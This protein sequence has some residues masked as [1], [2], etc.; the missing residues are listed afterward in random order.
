M[1]TRH[2][3]TLPIALLIGLSLFG[4]IYALTSKAGGTYW[5]QPLSHMADPH[6]PVHSD[7]LTTGE[8]GSFTYTSDLESGQIGPCSTTGTDDPF[9][10][11]FHIF[12]DQAPQATD[13]AWL[14]YELTGLLDHT[15]ICRSINDRPA[16]GGYM[17]CPSNQWITQ[18]EQIPVYG[19]HQGDNV[20]RFTQP[21]EAKTCYSIRALQLEVKT[22]LSKVISP[23]KDIVITIPEYRFYENK[24]YLKG[25]LTGNGAS[26]A[27]VYAGSTPISTLFG[28]FEC[29]LTGIVSDSNTW[30]IPLRAVFPN[31]AEILKTIKLVQKVLPTEVC[32]LPARNA[33]ST[34]L[35]NYSREEYV[36]LKG[37][38]LRLPKGALPENKL[39]MAI[40]LRSADLVPLHTDMVNVTQVAAGYRLLPHGT[41]FSKPVELSLAYDPALI[42]VGYTADDIRTFYFDEAMRQWVPLPRAALQ[43]D[44]A[45]VISYTTHFTDF[46]NGIIKVPES[47]ETQAFQPTSIKALKAANPGAGISMID[48]PSPNY[49]GTANLS[50]PLT[51]PPGRQGV[52]PQLAIQ[53]NSGGGNSWLGLGWDLSLPFIGIETRWGAPRFDSQLETETYLFNSEQLWPTAHRD[54]WAQRYPDGKEFTPRVEGAFDRIVRH[55]NSPKEYWWEVT[56]KNG[57]VN[58]YGGLPGQNVVDSAVLKTP[59]GNIAFWGLVKTVDAN[60]NF[61]RYHYT[62]VM[63]VGLP[64][65]TVSGYQLYPDKITYT[66]HGANEGLYEVRFRRDRQLP[67]N[68]RRPDVE[69]NCR[70]GLK[71]VTA[72]L[73]RKVEIR[74]D[75]NLVRS[76]ELNYKEGPFFKTLLAAIAEFD[77]KGIKFYEHTFDYFDDVNPGGQFTPLTIEEDWIVPDDKV[78]VDL[79]NPLKLFNG[80]T[81]VISGNKSSNFNVGVAVTVGGP[82]NLFSKSNTLG[83]NFSRGQ[84][85]GEG[86]IALVDINGDQLPDKVFKDKNSHQLFYSPNLAS[87][88]GN[89]LAAFGPKQPITGIKE[90]SQIKTKTWAKGLEGHPTPLFVGLTSTDSESATETYFADFNSDGLIDIAFKGIV[91]FNYLD[92]AGNPHFT[93]DSGKTPSYVVANAAVD[94]KLLPYDIDYREQ[95]I[96]D[97]PLHDVIRMWRAPR[98][99]TVSISAPIQLLIDPSPESQEYTKKDGIRYTIQVGKKNELVRD[100]ITNTTQPITKPFQRDGINVSKGEQIYF[101][102]Q[103]R[104]DGAFDQV[105]W[106][107]KIVYENNGNPLSALDADAK[108]IYQYQASSDFLLASAQRITM[109][110]SGQLRYEAPFIKP[111]LSDSITLV[112]LRTNDMG[113]DTLWQQGYGDQETVNTTFLDTLSIL[114]NDELRFLIYTS[115]TIDWQAIRW[116][117]EVAYIDADTDIE[118]FDPNGKPLIKAKPSIE[119]SLFSVER[120]PTKSLTA[121][122]TGKVQVSAGFIPPQDPPGPFYPI[123]QTGFFTIAV[124]KQHELVH[125]ETYEV[126]LLFGASFTLIHSTKPKVVNAGDEIFV[127][128]YFSNDTLAEQLLPYVRSAISYEFSGSDLIDPGAFA[129]LPQQDVLFGNLYRGWGQFA[130][131][132]NRNRAFQK[133]NE[134]ELKIDHTKYKTNIGDV[135][136]S[137][138]LDSNNDPTKE[139]FVLMVVDPELGMWRGYDDLTYVKSD[140]V[141]SSRMGEDDIQFE[142]F[143]A[144]GTGAA[145]PIKVST[146]S[147][148]SF[149]I[150]GSIPIPSPVSIS[151]PSPSISTSTQTNKIELVDMGG[152]GFPDML[153][154]DFVQ[155]TNPQGGLM[156]DLTPHN[157]GVHV[158]KADEFGFSLGGNT[159]VA[160]HSNSNIF[161]ANLI[162]NGES[163]ENANHVPAKAELSLGITGSFGQGNDAV[164]ESWIDINADGLPDKIKLGNNV[165]SVSLNLGYAFTDPE[166]W[167][168]RHI[169]AG[170]TESF[171][172][173]LGVNYSNMSLAFGVGLNRSENYSTD[174]LQ[175][176]NGDGLADMLHVDTSAQGDYRIY[177]YLNKGTEFSDSILWTSSTKRLDEGSATGESINGAFTFCIPLFFIRI[178]VNPQISGGQGVN[179]QFTQITD[180]QG[181]GFPDFIYS[182]DGNQLSVKSSTI[183]RTNLLRTVHRPMGSTFTLDYS[184][185]GNTYAL[186]HSK[187]VL[188]EIDVFDGFKDDGADH[189]YT[190]VLYEGGLHNRRERAF[191]G[192]H[193]VRI[194]QKASE[195]INSV[196]RT[197]VLTFDTS[198]YHRKG[199]LLSQRLIAGAVGN[200]FT[201]TRNTYVLKDVVNGNTL[202]DNFDAIEAKG[203]AFPALVETTELY[204][205][206]SPNA[207]LQHTMTYVYDNWGNVTDYEDQGDGSPGDGAF[208]KI[209]YHDLTGPYIKSVPAGITVS[210]DAGTIRRRETQIDPKG[211]VTRILQYLEDGSSVNHDMVYDDYGNL[212]RITRPPN[213]QDVRLQFEYTYDSAVFTYVTKV[214][215]GY[216][217]SS[218]G[219]FDYAFGQLLEATD[220]NGQ[221]TNYAIDD[222]GRIFRVTGP[223]ELASGQSPYTILY[224]YHPE[225]AEPYAVTRHYDPETKDD[226]VTVTFTDGLQ[227]PIQVK[228]T[229]VITTSPSS[230][231]TPGMIV[232]GRVIFDAFGR[233]VAEYYP[234]VEAPGLETIF[235][236]NFNTVEPTEKQYDVLDR[237]KIITLPDG[238]TTSFEFTIEEDFSGRNCFKTLTTDAEGSKRETY[239]DIRKR[240]YS[241]TDFGPNNAPI[242]TSYRYNPISELLSITDHLG[243]VITY[244]YDHLGRKTSTTHPDAGRTDLTY[245]PAGNVIRK[246]TANL[247][248]TIPNGGAVLYTYDHERLVQV[249]YPKNYQ[250]Q[251][252]IHYGTPGDK[253]NRAGRIWLR[254][255]ATGGTEYFYGPL[256]ETVKEI[257]TVLVDEFT[258]LTYVSEYTYD[259]WNRLQEMIYADGEV[260]TY[261]YNAAG[262]LQRMTGQK[263]N[264]TYVYVDQLGYDA[265]EQRSFI[266]YG[267]GTITTYTYEDTRRRLQTLKAG[268][269]THLFMDNQYTYDDV[270]N[271]ITIKNSAPA[272]GL[273]LGGTADYEF[274]YDELYRLSK[275]KGK[276][277]GKNSAATYSLEMAYDDLHNIQ[278]K[279]Q[280][281]Q[282]GTQTQ[283]K[284]TYDLE[285]KFGTRPHV[286]DQIGDFLY[287]YDANG[288][289]TSWRNNANTIRREL[290]WDE[291]D[292]LQAIIDNGNLNLYT[293]DG[294]DNRI[295]KSY[296][297]MQAMF[298]N[299]SPIG[300]IYHRNKISVYPNPNLVVR[301][302]QFTKHYYI[303]GQRVASK[304]GIGTF[305]NNILS[306]AKGITAGALDYIRRTR[307]LEDSVHA[308]YESLG[309]PYGPAG[310]PW[311]PHQPDVTGNPIP[312]L[313]AGDYTRPPA[314]WPQAFV[315]PFCKEPD[316]PLS[317][318]ITND[319]VKAGYGFVPHGALS[320][321]NQF[322]Y[323][324]DHL[325]STSYITDANGTVRQHVEYTAFGESFV[326]EHITSDSMPYLFNA[327]ELDAET[328]LYFY[329]ARYYDPR[330]SMWLSV[331]PMAEK[332]PDWSPYNYTLLNP[333]KFVDPD[334]RQSKNKVHNEQNVTN[335][336][337]KTSTTIGYR[338]E[339]NDGKSVTYGPNFK[340]DVHVDIIDGIGME[341]SIAAGGTDQRIG[342]GDSEWNT[343]VL[344]INIETNVSLLGAGAEVGFD[345]FRF[346]YESDHVDLGIIKASFKASVGVGAS[347][348]LNLNLLSGEFELKA[349]GNK[350]GIDL[351][352]PWEKKSPT[353]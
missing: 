51:I 54:N 296:G 334:G 329:G 159:V 149:S 309:I 50:Y 45:A 289:Q 245:D 280:T 28:E 202:S 259:T 271:V 200:P 148:V 5:P 232:S 331:D 208:A 328:G 252:K 184:R 191:Y 343:K 179:R 166:P 273:E 290:F 256:G 299:G 96:D 23:Q 133:I 301:T 43:Q 176:V 113:T 269:P 346:D 293:Y 128:L 302:D 104:T 138:D 139:N 327:K 206:G 194:Q 300:P 351:D 275:A 240:Q 197:T 243:N 140:I 339:S 332:Y 308:Y 253:H 157:L 2:F 144:G 178:C 352:L 30:S 64:S 321:T 348:G 228:K 284:T 131:N 46:I 89:K 77:R 26:E 188:S 274:T 3:P 115:T 40:P 141:S 24:A 201:E 288:N 210:I 47:P 305:Q 227:R 292:R 59:A 86:L 192:F 10:N 345:I 74:F 295:V 224:D 80:K 124:K 216:G 340:T 81:T 325:G 222:R 70:N 190:S 215:D 230:P 125:K 344:D 126:K 173:G 255:D 221:K 311:A 233:T 62:T 7:T 203:R 53:Y 119:N 121:P 91:F 185:V 287:S 39:L 211:N 265:F 318:S 314:L 111:E 155:H 320:E 279:T 303:E 181:D 212:Q 83:G 257:R 307:M 162:R 142:A 337:I 61:T 41:Q 117:P 254:E 219:V 82:G 110:F 338:Q 95:L 8:G 22:G 226:I 66:G 258:Q 277:Q 237:E 223:Y 316:V 291:E 267:N 174:A 261:T 196:Y 98:A 326:D 18:R 180:M 229:A 199:L 6:T 167:G 209:S 9:D 33:P 97:Y 213:H 63:D 73:L 156:P 127:D 69:I 36:S 114:A 281:H 25:F 322:F 37:M 21:P 14:S 109:P 231:A 168:I 72:D 15:A 251:V 130:L 195:N 4:G 93:P 282:I 68:K 186:P 207:G 122:S 263:D 193:K 248:A 101:R 250:N 16:I 266:K 294:E 105:V 118:I 175:D 19:L 323:H 13:E 161:P 164:R 171:G 283:H 272:I 20:I 75:G 189:M 342:N 34:K 238:S 336:G 143:T 247:Q 183:G 241:T 218:S 236:K 278:R 347:A 335:T 333:V 76:Y 42:P 71:Q 85:K 29:L 48:V 154:K 44:S 169:R 153:G 319:N 136:S 1:N 262:K 146:S 90:F 268:S 217:Y 160:S 150:S 11:V 286:P 285:Y 147:S 99:G 304:I 270:S 100:S 151:P 349:L 57:T 52:Q 249:D 123:K 79:V 27:Q 120:R 310:N 107:P 55:G 264:R 315:S 32:S 145:A 246:I 242:Y 312:P 67:G 65:G 235:N 132:G 129:V 204:F 297:T 234:I 182:G 317:G 170:E 35:V 163:G 306:T 38:R 78:D 135:N 31:G 260:V 102:L 276:W 239:Q 298:V 165:D 103:S 214:E 106:N 56:H 220:L 108:D 134:H 152:D 116:E 84:S 205:E 137:D 177:V 49:M 158:S 225:V 88:S 87:P 92:D 60:G 313:G 17:V 198:A 353:N 324:P 350:F 172:A 341:M 58:Y 94:D 12:L 244:T 112:I 330:V 187:W